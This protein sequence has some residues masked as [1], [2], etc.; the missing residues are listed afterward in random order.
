VG[1]V[2]ESRGEEGDDFVDYL[3]NRLKSVLGVC[4]VT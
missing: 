2:R 3:G 1:G 4:T